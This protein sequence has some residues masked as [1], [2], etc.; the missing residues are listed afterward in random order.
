MHILVVGFNIKLNSRYLYTDTVTLDE[1]NIMEIL[2]AAKMYCVDNLLEVC[3][4]YLCSSITTENLAIWIGASEQFDLTDLWHTCIQFIVQHSSIIF[5]GDCLNSL[6]SSSLEKILS[7]ENLAVCEA[8]VLCW[9]VK[10]WF[11]AECIRQGMNNDTTSL[12]TILGKVLYKV[13]FP[14]LPLDWFTNNV[15]KKLN[16]D[17]EF[18]TVEE[19]YDI[20]KSINHPSRDPQY[21]QN[22]LRRNI[23][24]ALGW[25]TFYNEKSYGFTLSTTKKCIVT[26]KSLILNTSESQMKLTIESVKDDSFGSS[27]TTHTFYVSLKGG[28]LNRFV[29]I[30]LPGDGVHFGTKTKVTSDK[31]EF[32]DNTTHLSASHTLKAKTLRCLHTNYFAIHHQNRVVLPTVNILA[33]SHRCHYMYGFAFTSHNV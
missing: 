33:A 6:S 13:R 3:E 16:T 2:N 28:E 23:F 15:V 8:T 12:R 30:I 20:E 7:S 24:D 19:I 18:L 29:N 27:A 21:F 26:L 14:L 5:T 10:F 32:A 31:C 1:Y 25:A 4:K 9:L 17:N 22:H 11:V